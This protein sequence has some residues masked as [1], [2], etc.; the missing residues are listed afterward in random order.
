MHRSPKKLLSRGVPV[1]LRRHIAVPVLV[2]LACVITACSAPDGGLNHE[3]M[4]MPEFGFLTISSSPE[5][6]SVYVA[7]DPL[8]GS[9]SYRSLIGTTPV[10]AFRIEASRFPYSVRVEAPGYLS[11]TIPISVTPLNEQTYHIELDPIPY[12]VADKDLGR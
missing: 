8:Q 5:N 2:A 7:M 6:A 4:M 3:E 1:R 11:R 12:G 10:K 9:K